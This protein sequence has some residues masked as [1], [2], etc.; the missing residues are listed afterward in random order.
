[1]KAL[2]VEIVLS[3]MLSHCFM[4]TADAGNLD[5]LDTTTAVH[6][7]DED[8]RLQREAASEAL[9]AEAPRSE[10]HWSNPQTGSSGS[11]QSLGDY[12]SDDGL[13][14]RKITIRTRAQG[15]ESR[16]TFPICKGADGGWF[17]ASGKKMMRVK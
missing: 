6:L 1:M 14:C 13:H 7:T 3:A 9:E 8:R 10:R 4:A 12:R 17:F 2:P 5:F 16:S 15:R 11:I